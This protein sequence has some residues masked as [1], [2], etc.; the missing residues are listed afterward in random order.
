M[1]SKRHQRLEEE[2]RLD[3]LLQREEE[4][5]KTEFCGLCERPLFLLATERDIPVAFHSL[6]SDTRVCRQCCQQ[7]HHQMKARN[8]FLH[9]QTPQDLRED[10][11]FVTYLRWVK[12]LPPETLYT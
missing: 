5:K 11:V 7:L 12:K 6:L 1:A 10:E 4:S 2:R 8:R 9:F 3:A